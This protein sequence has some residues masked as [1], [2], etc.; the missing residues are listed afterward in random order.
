[1]IKKTIVGIILACAACCTVPLLI[2]ALAGASIFGFQL[3]RGPLRLDTIL[4]AVAP[5][6]LAFL[7]V[8][9]AFRLYLTWKRKHRPTFAQ[10]A[11]Q[12]DGKCGCKT[13]A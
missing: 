4:C 8:Y 2:P 7:G 10:T 12:A 3:F 5:G 6:A 13:D 11:F 9:V 1:M